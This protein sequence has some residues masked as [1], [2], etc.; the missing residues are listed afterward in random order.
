MVRFIATDFNVNKLLTV[1][2][3]IYERVKLVVTMMVRS[4]TH[5]RELD[6]NS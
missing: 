5:R 1:G 6:F 2:C 4:L 3:L